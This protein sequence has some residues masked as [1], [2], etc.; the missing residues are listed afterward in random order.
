MRR[1]V[2]E[3]PEAAALR[4]AV[5][6]MSCAGAPTDCTKATVVSTT[7]A[8]RAGDRCSLALT[9]RAMRV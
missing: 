2:L 8:R 1:A 9:A 4:A 7:I 6:A 3:R 5:G